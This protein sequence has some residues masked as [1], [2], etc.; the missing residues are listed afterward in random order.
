MV[1][2]DSDDDDYA[3]NV[4]IGGNIPSIANNTSIARSSRSIYLGGASQNEYDFTNEAS[5]SRSNLPPLRK[6]T[7]D[8][9]FELIIGDAAAVSKQE[10]QPWMNVCTAVFYHRKN[11]KRLK[12]LFLTLTGF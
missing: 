9:S 6:W 11:P 3:K 2:L 1:E 4:N 7:R 10:E 12:K 8:H 5:S